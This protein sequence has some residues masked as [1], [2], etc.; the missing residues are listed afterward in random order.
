MYHPH[1]PQTPPHRHTT[2][3]TTTTAPPRT[4]PSPSKLQ[5][6]PTLTTTTRWFYLPLRLKITS[7]YKEANDSPALKPTTRERRPDTPHTGATQ[8]KP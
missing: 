5:T 7:I 2:P 1:D 8:I 3:P 6:A 4:S